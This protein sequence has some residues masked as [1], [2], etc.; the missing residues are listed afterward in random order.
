[1]KQLF[2]F[3]VLLAVLGFAAF[4]YRATLEGPAHGTNMASSTVAC[5]QEAKICPDGSSVGRTG[6]SCEFAACPLPNVELPQAGLAFALPAGY[7]AA[8]AQGSDATLI[9]AYEKAQ[10]GASSTLPDSLVVRRYPIPAGKDANAVMLA[11]TMY[12]S[13]G[14][15]PSSMDAFTPVII[16]G[17]TYQMIVVERFEA[18]VHVEYYLPRDHDVLRFEALAHGVPNWTDPSL[19]VRTLPAVSALET[20]LGTLQ[21]NEPGA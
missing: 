4:L 12:E 2:F 18:V 11:E 17:K 7:K 8:D 5:T 19:N 13:S 10:L 6:P 1:M 14:M 20:M 16:N 15:Q 3:V 9:G 21:S